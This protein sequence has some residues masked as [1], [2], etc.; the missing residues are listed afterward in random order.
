M[1]DGATLLWGNYGLGSN[2]LESAFSLSRR[3]KRLILCVMDSVL[4]TVSFMLALALRL[5]SFTLALAGGGWLAF[6]I[7]LPLTIA[8][9]GWMD[10]YRAVIRH[11]AG[12][13]LRVLA[14]GLGV[15]AAALFILTQGLSMPLPRSVPIIYWLIGMMLL[16]SARFGLKGI[17][18]QR[19]A[20][21]RTRVLI[22][23]AGSSGRQLLASLQCG[24]DYTPV[25]FVD[26]ARELRGREIGGC[27]VYSPSRIQ[28]LIVEYEIKVALLA[29]P[30]ATRR[31]RKI[32]IENLY[33]AGLY[34]RTIPGMADIIS[35]RARLDDIREVAIEDLLG[36]DLIPPVQQLMDANIRGKVVMVTGAGGSIGSELCR[37]IVRQAPATLVLLDIS[38][39]ALY[40]IDQELREILAAEGLSITIAVLLGSVLDK[41][42]VVTALARFSVDTIFHAA[43]YKHVP[44]VEQNV[45]QGV[46]NNVFGTLVLAQ[47]AIQAGVG[48]FVLI[49]TDKAVRPAN[50]M[51][52]SKRMAEL[53]CQAVSA[54]ESG[55]VFTIVRFGNVLGSSGSV[56][57]LF[58]R[59]I[60][61]GGP[62]MVTHPE[63]TRYF[64]AVTEAAQLV[65]QAGAM[66]R[67]GDV[68]ILDM[69]DPV[70]IVDLA[71][72][73]A[74]LSGLR[75]VIG[76][77]RCEKGRRP[78][79]EIEVRY[80][81]LRPGEKLYEELLVDA[82]AVPTAH[83]RI[84]T[85]VEASLGWPAL[86]LILER[87]SAS[88]DGY[89]LSAIREL[90]RSLPIGYQPL[91]EIA[92]ARS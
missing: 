24:G 9:F 38:E 52:A 43:A 87:L 11:V 40:Q 50:I 88:C 7:I 90:L 10:M 21:G 37:Q 27:R 67:G 39:F 76:E 14:I 42:I 15:A 53:I 2:L 86:E 62:I 81:G 34:V 46:R 59:Q 72:R 84:L 51:G 17:Y 12:P 6:F 22:F 8:F 23:G 78:H 31:Q 85:A 89:D 69:G 68:F 44:L 83:P 71:I 65:I 80:S 30:S 47:A 25:A 41:A 32:I 55:T 92:D 57:P 63:I 35:G 3:K 73:M 26:D 82:D 20:G 60:E 61:A 16:G 58:R 29:I 13:T 33:G 1:R 64:M 18:R 19:Q 48:T 4:L 45:I 28:Q 75:P 36:R 91:E 66:A 77:V 5:D 56:I 54:A 70:R 74:R 49:S 79:G